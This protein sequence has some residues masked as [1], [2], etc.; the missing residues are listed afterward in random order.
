MV[1]RLEYRREYRQDH[2]ERERQRVREYYQDNLERERQRSREY[3]REYSQTA[4]GIL[5]VVRQNAERRG[6]R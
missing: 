3:Q 6:N 4:A 2:L 5:R 1:A